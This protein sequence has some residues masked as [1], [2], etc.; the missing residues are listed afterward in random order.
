MG[1]FK[2]LLQS[3][4]AW[5]GDRDMEIAIRDQLSRDGWAG[6]S[7]KLADIKLAAVKR[8][9]WL[10]IYSFQ[11]AGTRRQGQRSLAVAHAAAPA[12]AEGQDAEFFGF[13]RHDA[14]TNHYQVQVFSSQA[15]RDRQLADVRGKL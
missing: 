15:S 8:P 6:R 2:D 7:A 1:F 12:V 14:R 13:V 4:N 5:C 11:G 9:G 3:W 10:Q